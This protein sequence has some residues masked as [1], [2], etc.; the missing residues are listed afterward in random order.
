M[1]EYNY[2]YR[3]SLS[4]SDLKLR[5][6]H[7]QVNH[8]KRLNFDTKEIAANLNLANELSNFLSFFSFS[9]LNFQKTFSAQ[10][11]DFFFLLNGKN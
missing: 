5:L 11:F 10:N 3:Y 6:K 1:S 8:S 4:Y 7:N 2:W 9:F